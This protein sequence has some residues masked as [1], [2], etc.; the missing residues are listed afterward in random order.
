MN[1]LALS[2]AG[3]LAWVSTKTPFS[4]LGVDSDSHCT[5]PD[6][7]SMHVV[8]ANKNIFAP[9]CSIG[10]VTPKKSK[11]KLNRMKQTK[12]SRRKGKKEEKKNGDKKSKFKLAVEL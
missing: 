1:S 7:A 3:K 8:T 12:S 9:V 5:K 10:N 2:I 4:T 6:N 11:L